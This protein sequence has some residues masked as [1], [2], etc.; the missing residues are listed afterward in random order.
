MLNSSGGSR[1]VHLEPQS[2]LG[3]PEMLRPQILSGL[4][5]LPQVP[6]N[7]Q[8]LLPAARTNCSSITHLPYSA[9]WPIQKSNRMD[10]CAEM[11]RFG[12]ELLSDKIMSLNSHKDRAMCGVHKY[13]LCMCHSV[14]R[15]GDGLTFMHLLVTVTA[16]V[17][18][19]IGREISLLG[20]IL[21]Y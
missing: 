20:C 6:E 8:C 7:L 16:S 10:L 4:A 13:R 18:S 12:V 9:W 14:H 2:H 17:Q 15:R 11:G 1:F 3:A 19:G 5:G 21:L